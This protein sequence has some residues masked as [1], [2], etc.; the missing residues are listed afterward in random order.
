M[1][2]DPLMADSFMSPA[3]AAVHQETDRTDEEVMRDY[4]VLH[5]QDMYLANEVEI[6]DIT[7]QQLD[8]AFSHVS[9]NASGPDAYRCDDEP[10][11]SLRSTRDWDGPGR[12][13]KHTTLAHRQTA[14]PAATLCPAEFS[15]LSQIYRKWATA[16][17]GSKVGLALRVRLSPGS[18]SRT[19]VMSTVSSTQTHSTN[20]AT[21][22]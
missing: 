14:K 22:M 17:V 13:R 20:R 21:D 7:T 6:S 5:A 11:C 19:C 4:R 3:W 18:R 2:T 12:P 16:P 9:G 1:H 8:D 10:K 15:L